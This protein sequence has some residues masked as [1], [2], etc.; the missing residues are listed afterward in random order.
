MASVNRTTVSIQRTLHP[1]WQGIVSALQ[2]MRPSSTVFPKMAV[3]V[4]KSVGTTASPKFDIGPIVF[5][6]PERAGDT[7]ASLYVVVEGWISFSEFFTKE[8]KP[9]TLSFGTRVAYFRL[10]QNR[11][12]HVYGVHYDMDE[13]TPGHPVFH[14]QLH[15]QMKFTDSIDGYLRLKYE[16]CD[17]LARG[18]LGNV[19]TPTAQM[20]AFSVITQI[21]ADH[22]IWE[23]SGPEV[24]AAFAR[25]RTA[26]DFFHGAG[27]RLPYLK[28]FPASECYRSTHWYNR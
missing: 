14:A 4:F 1:A 20:D 7:G 25:L 8:G 6:V 28:D 11:L 23:R 13:T 21:G 16:G 2:Q 18:L 9:I 15:S 27:G 17:D 3:D 5:N 12:A 19:R 10:K 26:C 24:L 22:L